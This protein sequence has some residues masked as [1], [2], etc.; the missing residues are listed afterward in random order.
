MS[1]IAYAGIFALGFTGVDFSSVIFTE[2]GV[3]VVFIL[4]L[5]YTFYFRL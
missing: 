4:A 5:I 3:I 1:T 2:V